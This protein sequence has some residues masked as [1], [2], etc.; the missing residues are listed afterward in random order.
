MKKILFFFLLFPCLCPAQTDSTYI[1]FFEQE[2]ALRPYVYDKFTALSH[3]IGDHD[4]EVTYRPNNPFG[5]GLGI[6]WKNISLSG[7]YGFD[8]MRNKKKGKTRSIDFQYHYYG[9]KFVMDFF[10]QDYKGFFTEDEDKDGVYT[11]F[12]DI[13]LKQYGIFGQ[14][15]FN[16]RKFSY[17][18]AFS[19][20]EKQLKSA[21]S[22]L[23][24]GGIYYNQAFSDSTIVESIPNKL[25]NYQIG[26][27]GGYAYTWVFKKNFYLSGSFSV[28]VNLGTES[29]KI[30]KVEVYP[31]LFP[32]M[33]MGYN[34]DTW[35]I[36][37]S[38]VNN[39]VYVHFEDKDKL[40]FDTGSLQISFVKRFRIA[41]K[42]IRNI[43][44]EPP[45]F[46]PTGL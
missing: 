17:K 45:A 30:R 33:S 15:V 40:S 9:R 24:G 46:Y 27:S 37:L 12:P 32:R 11:L 3:E 1:G 5:I 31:S 21:G 35:S 20:N 43:K 41:P 29:L 16:G 39:R 14:Y 4:E 8:F 6:T 22:F 23:L 25:N 44:W 2:L 38:G 42:L 7:G 28:G 34:S 26:V 13:R 19:Q 36:A 18:A 10:F